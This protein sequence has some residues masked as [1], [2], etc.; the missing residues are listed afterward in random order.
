V[1]SP[2]ATPTTISARS[3]GEPQLGERHR[4]R[5]YTPVGADE[6]ELS[7]VVELQVVE[8]GVGCVEDAEAHELGDHLDVRVVGPVDE[9]LVAQDPDVAEG[10]LTLGELVGSV[11]AAV[12]NDDR[13]VVDPVLIRQ[14]E[15]GR[16]GIVDDE[17]A[18]HTAVDVLGGAAVQVRVEPQ[19]G[20][21]L[22][23]RPGG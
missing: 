9:D 7:V 19:G 15:C 14:V 13:D 5:E 12:L 23:D 10:R 16:V 4:H 22:V 20:G 17:H 1:R 3:P 6:R 2:G 11:E 18:R 8:A 21:R